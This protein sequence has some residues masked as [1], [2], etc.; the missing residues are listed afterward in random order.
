MPR[1]IAAFVCIA[2]ITS[3]SICSAQGMTEQDI[4]SDVPKV[5]DKYDGPLRRASLSR[6]SVSAPAPVR[7]KKDD[8][9]SRGSWM[10]R[11]PALTGALLG[12][13]LGV[14]LTYAVTAGDDDDSLLHPV[15][16]GG[17]AL[18]Y[19]GIAAGFGALAGWGISR[20]R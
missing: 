8:D 15:D 20:N 1:R 3:S 17:P 18:V 5:V 14:G 12:F 10:E 2:S 19:G 13:G 16:A 11:H 4:R 7:G 9:A 6:S